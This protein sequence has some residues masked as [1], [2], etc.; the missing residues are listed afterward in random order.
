MKKTF[1]AVVA[2]LAFALAG[3]VGAEER[4]FQ[5]ME[6]FEGLHITGT[7]V[8]A[9][10]AT[11]RLSVSGKVRTSLSLSF[12]EVKKLPSADKKMVLDCPG[13]F[14]DDGVWT[15]VPA[16]VL[17]EEAGIL[18]DAGVVIFSTE[19]GTYRT[20]FPVREILDAG[21]E[22]LV[23]YRFNG[24]E[25]HKVHGFPLRLAARGKEGS[26]WVKWLGKIIVE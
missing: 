20:R 16:R 15:G 13:F 24:R 8:D 26:D 2:I 5:Y 9:D 25:F 14:T 18:P 4:Q 10:P 6:F 19:D 17:L 7:P 12:D 11:Y 1:A 21:D 3:P 22:M 23:A